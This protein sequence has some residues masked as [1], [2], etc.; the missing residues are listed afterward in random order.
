M[1]KL[2]LTF[3]KTPLLLLLLILIPVLLQVN[4]QSL[5]SERATL[6]NVKQQWGNPPSIQSWNSSSSPCDW[7]EIICAN[8][9]VTGINL[10]DK[11]ITDK[12][13]AT[14]CDLRN[15]NVLNLT[16][17]YIPGE[18]PRV[19]YN[20]SKL[21][22]L[23]LSQNYFVGP[24]PDDIDQIPTLQYIDLGANNFSGDI[25]KA[26]GSLPE[27]HTLMLYQN[28]FNGTFPRE[29]GNLSN[30][31]VLFMAYNEFVPAPIPVD[32]GR[33]R[34]LRFMWMTMTNLVGGIP[35]NISSLPSLE[36]LN[37]AR[38]NLVGA[39]PSGLF[40]L[41][42]L[43][44][45]YL[46]HNRLSGE[47]PRLVESTNLIEIDLSMNNLRG[48]I[49]EDFGKLQNLKLL[50]LF[51]N[52]LT[53]EIPTSLGKLPG[54][55]DFRVFS[56]KLT[57]NLPAELGLHSKLEAVEVSGNQL[58]GQLPQHLCDGGA[59]QGL[60]AF[61]NNFGGELPKWVGN[62][63]TLRTV[64]FQENNF[65]GE[66]PSG[67]WT[68][69]NLS[70]LMLTGN[71]FSGE[72]P[73]KF[74]KNLSRLEIGNNK[75]SGQI[76]VG[77]SSWV[78]LVVFEASN[79]LLSGKIPVE[80]TSLPH[81]NSLLLDGNQLSG[82]LPSE[83]ISW[84]SLTTL[85][86]SRNKLSGQIPAV[87]ASLPNLLYLD[88]SENQLSGEIPPEIGNLRLTSLNLSSNQLSGKIPYQFENYEN[89]FLNNPNLCADNPIPG[90]PS[91]YTT[92]LGSSNK[93]SSTYVA[94][95]IVLAVI[96]FLVSVSLAVYKLRGCRTKKCGRNLETWKITSFRRLDFKQL[97]ILSNLTENNRIGSGG[98]GKVYRIATDRP[99]EFVAVKRIWSD[100]T[101]DHK[102]EKEFMAEVQVLGTI[103]HS[104]IVKL[105]CCFSSED[106]KLLVYEY[107]ENQS[108]DKWL[109]GKK[110]KSSAGM[111]PMHHMIL[112]WPKRLQIAIGAAQGLYYMHHDCSPP[113]I[114]RDVK[115]SNILLDSEF[116]ASI[117]DFGLARIL[118]KYGK[119]QTMS[120]VAGSIG[121]I[122][123][124]YAYTSK[125]NEKID[126]YSF[127]V[128][129]LELTTGRDAKSGDEHMSLAEWSWWYYKEGKP[130][131]DALDNEI[132]KPC[133]LEEMSSVFKLGLMCTGRSPST[134]PSMKEVLQIL[135]RCGPPRDC[136]GKKKGIEFDVA[137]LLGSVTYLSSYKQSQKVSEEDADNFV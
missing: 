124:E 9:T 49:P 71:S 77:V 119:P 78:N 3:P 1:S 100:K 34:K 137:P 120:I 84:K 8:G 44:Y 46:F 130:I 63:T 42:N 27:L 13:P 104:N 102:L 64:Q 10:C 60:T 122:A 116:K 98:S 37:L 14:I 136:E 18:F 134:R 109:H 91:C 26:I 45:V 67:L 70:S 33:L 16:Y 19:L 110:R 125:V 73:S 35:E 79:N 24:I 131:I 15:L 112:D 6:L 32:F 11:N 126:I 29:I 48:S 7:P 87:V 43:S 117:A 59:L 58:S 105:L 22:I 127:G 69:L 41:K 99:G 83:I 36:H 95:I 54:L 89:S 55:I 40:L 103:R 96:V 21:K 107:K 61:S 76:P 52:Q 53:G 108:L 94:M 17:N 92:Q 28:E 85:N 111:N 56:N 123:P 129:L 132:K 118:D 38:N 81:L 114:H 97:N 88:L 47:I 115:S 106:T 128:V 57:G 66:I 12:I 51:T 113:I 86:L 50:S 121:Y 62:C 72:L 39:I 30:L 80:L 31:E 25:P 90:I 75:F 101:V 93:L 20:C 74:A 2:P 5:N 68:S 23:D 4:S 133:Y 65:S 82:E 135:C